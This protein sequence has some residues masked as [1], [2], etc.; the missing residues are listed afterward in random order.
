MCHVVNHYGP[1][2]ATIGA[3]ICDIHREQAHQSALTVPI[4]RPLANVEIVI[5]DAEYQQVPIGVSGEIYIGGAGLA[6]GYLHQPMQTAE[7]FIPNPFQQGQS[8]RLYRTGDIGRALPDG[9][10]EFLHRNDLQVKIRGFRVEPG[11]IERILSLHPDVHAAAITI[12]EH[13]QQESQIVAYVTTKV[14]NHMAVISEL[15]RYLKSHLPEYMLPSTIVILKHLPLTTNG[16]I[17]YRSLSNSD[18][19][20]EE[21]EHPFIAPRT[22]SEEIVA[23][24]MAQLLCCEKISIDDNFFELG[25]HSL[26]ATQLI[27]RLR[28]VF[29]VEL[30]VRLLFDYP[31]TA[32]LSVAILEITMMQQ[33]PE[34]MTR[35]LQEIQDL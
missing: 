14:Q 27:A 18:L 10:I 16:K 2:E 28:E 4:G 24:L 19:L 25:G 6:R 22:P 26:L 29:Q 33:D 3:T 13:A 15:K 20:M 5:L 17:D 11:E 8:N 7:C 34:E 9:S 30:P 1:T 35:I 31:T 32:E 21:P 12:C 23:G